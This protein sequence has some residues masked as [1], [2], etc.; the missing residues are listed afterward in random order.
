M[1]K[2]FCP[3]IANFSHFHLHI[4]FSC[5][6]ERLLLLDD[7]QHLLHHFN[8]F[9]AAKNWT[10]SC[11]ENSSVV[12]EKCWKNPFSRALST[13]L[14]G[15]EVTNLCVNGPTIGLANNWTKAFEANIMPTSTVSCKSS[16]CLS[17]FSVNSRAVV[18]IVV[19]SATNP[20]YRTF[21][22]QL[23]LHFLY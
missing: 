2:L 23:D 11:I 10:P 14:K 21:Q 20:R 8:I 22:L 12:K 16:R 6:F 19:V 9:Y 18:L 4:P 17:F 15:Q 1:K 5:S 3:S 13:S 7:H